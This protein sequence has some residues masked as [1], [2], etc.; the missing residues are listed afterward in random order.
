MSNHPIVHVEIPANNPE[1]AGKFYADVFG[2]NVQADQMYNYVQFQ[3]AGGLGGGFVTTGEAGTDSGAVHYKPDSLLVYIGTDDIDATLAKIN[4]LGG[5][6]LLPKAEIP[7]IGW[8]A[9]FSDPTGNR[10]ALFTGAGQQG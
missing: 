1:A 10:V 5:K 9:L 7:H 8:F 2:W 3:A 4:S 6:T